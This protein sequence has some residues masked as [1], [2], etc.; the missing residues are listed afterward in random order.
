MQRYQRAGFFTTHSRF[1]DRKEEG[2]GFLRSIG[3]KISQRETFYVEP[4]TETPD[5]ARKGQRA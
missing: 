3:L 1:K 4:K 5:T 2:D